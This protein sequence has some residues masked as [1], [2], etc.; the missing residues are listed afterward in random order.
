MKHLIFFPATLILIFAFSLLIQPSP[1]RA[2]VSQSMY[3]HTEATADDSE[4]LSK[5]SFESAD[6]FSAAWGNA[7]MGAKDQNDEIVVNG[8]FPASINLMAQLIT[9]P[10]VQSS[11]YFAD[12]LHN[13]G[14]A[15]PAYA[16]GI[17]FS[18]L[19]PVL[20][21]WKAFRNI[22]YFIFIIIFVV[23]GF[24]IMFRAQLNPQTV[25]TVQAALPKMVLTLILITFSYAIAGFVVDLIYLLFFVVTSVLAS[26]GILNDP[27]KTRDVL[28][29]YSV[30]RIGFKYLIS[31]WETAGEASQAAGNL[32]AAAMGVPRLLQ[33]ISST[34]FYLII[35]VAIII[36]MFRTLFALLMAWVGIVMGVIFAPIQLLLN[37]LPQMNTFGGWLKSLVANALLFPAVGI[38]LIIAVYL[39]GSKSTQITDEFG[40][41]TTDFA[42]G[43]S[44][45]GWVPPLVTSK[46][47]N[48]TGTNQVQAILGIGMLMLLPEVSKVIKGALGADDK[49]GLGQMIQANLQRGAAPIQTVGRAG[50]MIVGAT[51]TAAGNQIVQS[52]VSRY[53][54]W[55]AGGKVAAHQQ[56]IEKEAQHK[57]DVAQAYKNLN[58][59]GAAAP[60]QALGDQP[61]PVQGNAKRV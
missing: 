44:G 32:F 10:P 61:Q 40:I 33:G 56:A 42:G 37:A 29:G 55:R 21:V 52:G 2:A 43:S 48:S 24:M 15:Q 35:A 51:A 22:A 18:A 16:Q 1:A 3:T 14:V 36:A 54:T 45:V 12:V 27:A 7:I 58:Q 38:M 34:V 60:P 25:V 41:N 46:D 49:L 30:V 13:F 19:T 11:E 5:F 28:F 53:T 31:P 17:G 4:N 39:T 57:K 8:A 50:G 6:S 26:F 47:P 23:V 59:P 9:V 20:Q